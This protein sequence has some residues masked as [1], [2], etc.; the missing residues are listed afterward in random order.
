MQKRRC[1]FPS[2]LGRE[3]SFPPPPG[4]LTG[5]L[6]SP[7]ALKYAFQTHDRLCFVMEYANGGEVSCRPQPAFPGVGG[8]QENPWLSRDLGRSGDLLGVISFHAPHPQGSL[9]CAGQAQA[10]GGWLG[11]LPT[12]TQLVRWWT[13]YKP[14]SRSCGEGC[15]GSSQRPVA[16]HSHPLLLT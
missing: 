2:Q 12:F 9:H 11:G 7:Q 15:R 4:R 10:L 5:H 3:P 14:G 8:G 16:L 13:G 1:P 6:P